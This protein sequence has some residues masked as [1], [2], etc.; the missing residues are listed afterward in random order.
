MRVSCRNA[1]Y[2]AIRYPTYPRIE[3]HPD[4]LAAVATLFGMHPA[5]VAHCRV[6]EIGC[7]DGGNLMPMAYFL[8]DSRFLG[9]D[10]AARCNRRW[11]SP[12]RRI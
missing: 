8:P 12:A 7:G 10:L 3:T 5:P 4:R 11:Q 6:L 1:P 2:D 9:V